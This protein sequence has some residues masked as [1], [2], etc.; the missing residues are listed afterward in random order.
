VCGYG[1]ETIPSPSPAHSAIS[2]FKK[3][4]TQADSATY[5]GKRTVMDIA[6]KMKF[7]MGIHKMIREKFR[8]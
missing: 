5:F 4:L 3:T 8:N 6:S 7:I 1:I 2:M